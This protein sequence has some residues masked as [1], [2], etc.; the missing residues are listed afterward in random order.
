MP[1]VLL[2][3]CNQIDASTC[4]GAPWPVWVIFFTVLLAV[5]CCYVGWLMWRS[6]RIR[7]IPEGDPYERDG[8]RPGGGFRFVGPVVTSASDPSRGWLFGE[9]V[10]D[11]EHVVLR[12][13]RRGASRGGADGRL[14]GEVRL[15]RRDVR[16]VLRR[17]RVL[18]LRRIGFVTAADPKGNI[19]C[20]AGRKVVAELTAL[21]WPTGDQPNESGTVA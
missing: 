7:P 21:G 6:S 15:A 12:Y 9:M 13:R 3:A 18:L 10:V 11:G 14:A 19:G 2:A 1:A 17:D 20:S 5:P 4:R 16:Q 8:F